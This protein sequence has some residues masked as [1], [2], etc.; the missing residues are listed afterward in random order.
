MEKN[1]INLYCPSCGFGLIHKIKNG[2]KIVGGSSGAAA[3]AALGAKIGIAM[4]PLGA[5]AGTVPGAILGGI[6]GGKAGGNLD[7]PQCPKCGTKFNLPENKK[8]LPRERQT[9]NA[10]AIEEEKEESGI[11]WF[12]YFV[13]I[14][15]FCMLMS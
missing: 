8:I 12:W 15:A 10:T 13:I 2:G 7:N 11:N 5:I 4:G 14:I 9:V 1:E 3:G 6:F